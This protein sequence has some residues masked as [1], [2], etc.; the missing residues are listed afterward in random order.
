MQ[1]LVSDRVPEPVVDRLEMIEIEHEGAHRLA[2][3]GLLRDQSLRRQQH[4]TP[5]EQPGQVVGHGGVLVDTKRALGR[6]HQ[7][8]ERCADRIEHGLQH[9]QRNPSGRKHN[10]AAIRRQ[11]ARQRDRE[12]EYGAVQHRN[13]NGRPTSP[14][15]LA[16]LTP[17]LGRGRESVARH[18]DR[19][20]NDAGRRP[21]GEIGEGA[22]E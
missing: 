4:P 18:D 3:L 15:G 5:V 6:E 2:L 16:A 14:Q 21:L 11:Q 13:Q 20:Q 1:C 12:Q 9:E 19:A 8:D 10:G 22:G 7:N 17:Q